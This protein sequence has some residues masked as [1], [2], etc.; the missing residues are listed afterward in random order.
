MKEEFVKCSYC[1]ADVAAEACKLAAH[2]RVIDGK[3]Y[4]FCCAN[5]A[6]RFDKKRSKS[7]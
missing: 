5:C 1:R 7:Q 3:Q 2:R 4:V 6:D